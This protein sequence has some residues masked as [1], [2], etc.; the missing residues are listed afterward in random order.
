M[1][2]Q[3]EFG[4]LSLLIKIANDFQVILSFIS[5]FEVLMK[6]NFSS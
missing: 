3:P 1:A 2:T 5:Y 4:Q 6:F